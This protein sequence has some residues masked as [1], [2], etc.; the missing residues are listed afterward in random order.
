MMLLYHCSPS[1]ICRNELTHVYSSLI[2]VIAVLNV[3]DPYGSTDLTLDL[4]IQR[5]VIIIITFD[6]HNNSCVFTIYYDKD[7][8]FFFTTYYIKQLMY[9]FYIYNDKQNMQIYSLP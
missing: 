7:L 9:F 2:I 8:T 5:L 1:I 3:P 4:N 6:F